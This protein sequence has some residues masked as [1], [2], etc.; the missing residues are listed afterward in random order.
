MEGTLSSVKLGTLGKIVWYR[1][2]DCGM[3]SSSP[4]CVICVEH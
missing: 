3:Q 2:R 1:C 4:V